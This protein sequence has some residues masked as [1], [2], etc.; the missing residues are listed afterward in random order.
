MIILQLQSLACS[1]TEKNCL[2][3]SFLSFLSD[4]KGTF[5]L[6]VKNITGLLPG[7]KRKEGE[8]LVETII[9]SYQKVGTL[10]YTP[11]MK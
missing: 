7:E 6:I 11:G 2:D 4:N 9:M 8:D 1:H 5:R 3:H 10:R